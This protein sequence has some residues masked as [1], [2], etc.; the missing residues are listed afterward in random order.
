VSLVQFLLWW[1]FP[2]IAIVYVLGYSYLF[3]PMRTS[4]RVPEIVRALFDCPMCL[5][6]WTGALVGACNSIPFQWPTCGCMFLVYSVQRIVLGLLAGIAIQYLIE[7]A[8]R[9]SG[10]GEEEGPED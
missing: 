9:R 3:E 2:I 7:L 10:H 6:A 1:V 5:G 4:Q 8:A